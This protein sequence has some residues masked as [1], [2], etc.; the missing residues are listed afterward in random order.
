VKHDNDDELSKAVTYK[1]VDALRLIYRNLEYVT[2]L[3]SYIV[4]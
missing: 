2:P 4:I 3:S 1:Y